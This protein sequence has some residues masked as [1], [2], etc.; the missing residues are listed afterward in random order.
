MVHKQYQ[1][2]NCSQHQSMNNPQV[3]L[4]RMCMIIAVNEQRDPKSKHINCLKE[5]AMEDPLSNAK[6]CPLS[7]NNLTLEE[8]NKKEPSQ[9][10]ITSISKSFNIM[11]KSFYIMT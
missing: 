7:F 1:A 10:F 4:R 8:K 11:C 9:Y 3:P 6:L 5:V 2:I